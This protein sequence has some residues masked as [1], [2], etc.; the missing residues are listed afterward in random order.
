MDAR[1]STTTCLWVIRLF[2]TSWTGGN[3]RS[4]HAKIRLAVTIPLNL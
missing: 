4:V 3:P 2:E 1:Y